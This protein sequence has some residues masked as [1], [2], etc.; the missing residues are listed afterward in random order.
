MQHPMHKF[1]GLL[2]GVGLLFLACHTQAAPPAHPKSA[3]TPW[4]IVFTSQGNFVV[5]LFDQ[6]VPKTV[7]HFVGLATGSKPW[8]DPK[9]KETV[10]KPLYRNLTFHRIVPT[11]MLQTGC[12]LGNGKGGPGY[13]I[14]DEFHPNLRHGG[15]GYVS[16]ANAGPNT[17]GSQFYITLRA[18]PWLDVKEIKGKYCKNFDNPIRCTRHMDCLKYARMFPNAADGKALCEKRTQKRGHTVFGK[19]VHGLNVLTKISELPMDAN[20]RPFQPVKL[21]RIDIRRG[22]R[23]QRSWLRAKPSK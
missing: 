9:T 19:V 6:W 21:K 14:Q 8:Q 13:T 20:G 12:P 16:M 7:A 1:V 23:W 11:Y 2:L 17:N 4:A 22:K 18:T 3:Q 15:P 5:E 10:R